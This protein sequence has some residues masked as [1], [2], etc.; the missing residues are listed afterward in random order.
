MHKVDVNSETWKAVSELVCKRL[1]EDRTQREM[2][3]T[4]LRQLDRLLGGVR[5]LEEILRLPEKQ[6][7]KEHKPETDGVKEFGFQAPTRTF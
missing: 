7:E 6:K 2:P 4:E 1:K 5:R 3:N